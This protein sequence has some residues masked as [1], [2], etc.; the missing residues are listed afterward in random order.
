MKKRFSLTALLAL[1]ALAMQAQINVSMGKT[2]RK[3]TIDQRNKYST[4]Q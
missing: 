4:C 1:T 2:F 3:D